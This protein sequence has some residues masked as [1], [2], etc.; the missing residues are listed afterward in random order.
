[1][2]YMT[3]CFCLTAILLAPPKSV[4]QNCTDSHIYESGDVCTWANAVHDRLPFASYSVVPTHAPG[5]YSRFRVVL[6]TGG[7]EIAVHTRKLDSA[8]RP[9]ATDYAILVG[10]VYARMPPWLQYLM[11]DGLAVTDAAT[12]GYFPRACILDARH[13]GCGEN[14]VGRARFMI[15][16][17]AQYYE[18]GNAFTPEYEELFL[19]ELG[20]VFER[21]E[22]FDRTE[23]QRAVEADNRFVTDYATTN[24]REDFA[25]SFAAWVLWR[26]YRAGLSQP[27]IAN[28]EA[29]PNRL[30]Y[31][32]Q[33][34]GRALLTQQ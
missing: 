26:S 4:A 24:E 33:R 29:I 10:S 14:S 23:W 12:G 28:I 25:E 3:A 27:A 32:D 22:W 17:P 8:E 7:T 9:A 16:L 1:M 11:P 20:H 30:A 2:R 6:G 19:H 34:L 13:S 5:G 15:A 18:T 31:F 21:M